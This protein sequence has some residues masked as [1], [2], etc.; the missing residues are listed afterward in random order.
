MGIKLKNIL[1][2]L[3]LL[4]Y[5]Y[6]NAQQWM[7]VTTI[8]KTTTVAGEHLKPGEVYDLDVCPGTKRNHINVTDKLGVGY[9]VNDKVIIGIT[10][11]GKDINDDWNYDVFARYNISNNLLADLWVTCEYNY[12]H[13]QD[14]EYTDHMDLG[15]MYSLQ[16][17]DSFYLEPNYTKSIKDGEEGQFNISISYIF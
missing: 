14:E 10:R 1:L 6:V 13:S 15:L 7:V 5:S 8:S 11:A 3:F 17:W 9:I 16:V 4:T 12:L 2:V